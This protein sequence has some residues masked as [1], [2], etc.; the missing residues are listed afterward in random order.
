MKNK[1]FVNTTD[2][3]LSFAFQII[4]E[5]FSLGKKLEGKILTPKKTNGASFSIFVQGAQIIAEYRTESDLFSSF[6]IVLSHID[7]DGFCFCGKW[8][9]ER[10]GV[11]LDC[12][13]NAVP[14]KS[15]LK[16]FIMLAALFGFNYLELYTEDCFEVKG[17][18]LF[19]YMRGKYSVEDI[20]EIDAY[21]KLFAIELIPCIQTLAHLG[22]IFMHWKEYTEK[23]R[24]VNDL[25]LVDE[26][27][28]YKLIENI[29]ASC[30][31]AFSS[32]NINIG[33]DEPFLLGKG[34]YY[35]LHGYVPEEDI[36][37]K[38]LGKVLKICE[39]YGFT[40]FLWA[41]VFLQS[42]T[43]TEKFPKDPIYIFWDYTNTNEKFYSDRFSFFTK[44]KYNFAFAGALH[45]WYGFTPQN[46]Y[47]ISIL[48]FQINMAKKYCVNDFLVTLWG[49]EGAECSIFAVLPAFANAGFLFLNKMPE[50]NTVFTSLFG[51]S[52]DEFLDLDLP[53]K[54]YDG[55]ILKLN[56]PSKYLFYMD[57]L[58]GLEEAESR[59]D[60]PERYIQIANKLKKNRTGHGFSYLFETLYRVSL[61][62]EKKATIA[63]EL[64]YSYKQKDKEKLKKLKKE[65]LPEC[66][67][68]LENFYVVYRSQ[69]EKENRGFGF[70]VQTYRICGLKGRLMEVKRI[71]EE[72]LE[73]KR[74][75]ITEL[76]EERVKIK[77][78]DD[79]F[80]GCV[81][82]NGFKETVTYCSF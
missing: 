29:I 42:K 43:N 47:S 82:Y 3:N 61:F 22:R 59:L 36:F 76:E 58:Y 11:M 56:N 73:G 20:R 31:N 26:E 78:D 9:V 68:R 16:R 19:G 79:I 39:K 10:R 48:S 66:I 5:E 4:V 8:D 24:D 72:Y 65:I 27:R 64:Y 77:K 30:R 71:L 34:K 67:K 25:L 37:L 63:E 51:I 41:D 60:Y 50:L 12:A 38:H 21:C 55:K 18:P 44:N 40:P 81:L 2:K 7:E 53:N 52:Y 17:E 75:R 33:M 54:L 13:R 46:T 28:T 32:K 6:A 35:R 15:T 45:K 70:E 1:F 49:D 23:I 74:E 14:K 80:N 57:P 69:W 62:L